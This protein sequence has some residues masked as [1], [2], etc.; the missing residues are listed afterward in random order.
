MKNSLIESIKS[1]IESLV[2]SAQPETKITYALV[3]VKHDIRSKR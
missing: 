2:A 1:V 3:Y